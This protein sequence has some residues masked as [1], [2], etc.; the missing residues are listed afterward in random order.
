MNIPHQHTGILLLAFGGPNSLEEVEPFLKNIFSDRP[1]NPFVVKEVKEHYRLIGGKSPLLEITERQSRLLQDNLK[2]I[3]KPYEVYIGM[4]CWQPTISETINAMHVKGIK[5]ILCIILSPFSTEAVTE[6]YTTAVYQAI[7]K[8]PPTI[9]VRFV[10]PWNTHPRYLD[11]AA[12]KVKEALAMFPASVRTSVPLV[13]SAHSLPLERVSNDPYV[14][15]IKKTIAGVIT[16]LGKNEW[17]LAFQSRGKEGE[18]LG[19]SV[20]EVIKHLAESRKKDVLVVPLG[21]VSDHLE[22]L[23]DLDIV[24]RKKTLDVGMNFQRAPSLNASPKFIEALTEVIVTSL[25]S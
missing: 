13:F 21:F 17:F 2:K 12:D 20:G 19:P 3:G 22:T 4:R 14:S 24:L 1:L 10:L 9:D 16:R 11:A 25:S 15:E 7:K 6:G 18:W 8:S 23:Y 5:K